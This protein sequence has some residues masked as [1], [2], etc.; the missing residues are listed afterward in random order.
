MIECKATKSFPG[1]LFGY[2]HPTLVLAWRSTDPA[3]DLAAVRVVAEALRPHLDYDGKLL[4]RASVADQ[5]ATARDAFLTVT[6]ALELSGEVPV[7]ARRIEEDSGQGEDAQGRAATIFAECV[8][9]PFTAGSVN[10][11]NRLL[12]FYN[13]GIAADELGRRAE[14]L[15]AA[16]LSHPAVVNLRKNSRHLVRASHDRALPVLRLPRGIAQYGWGKRSTV[17]VSSMTQNTSLVSSQIAKDKPLTRAVLHSA[18]LPVARQHN[19]RDLDKAISAAKDIGYPV[20]VKPRSLDGGKGVTTNIRDEATL[21]K[22]FAKVKA[23][24]PGV[25]VEEHL[26]GGEYRLLVVHGK[27]IAIHERVPAQVVANGRDTVAAL[28]EAENAKRKEIELTG[29][30]AAPIV[31][32]DETMECLSGQGLTMESV[33]DDGQTVRM[34]TV[35]KVQTGGTVRPVAFSEFHPDNIDAVLRAARFVRLDIAGIDFLTP[36]P[37]KSWRE[38]GGAITEVNAVP[39]INRLETFDVFSA[40]LDQLLPEGGRL[41]AVL[42][43]DDTDDPGFVAQIVGEA[44]NDK[45]DPGVL[46]TNPAR[47]DRWESAISGCT[48]IGDGQAV[49]RDPC[50]GSVLAVQSLPD[51]LANGY[52][53]D[54]FDLI[55][56]RGIADPA[57]A[58]QLLGAPFRPMFDQAD[59]VTLEAD[60]AAESFGELAGDR[61]QRVADEREM[62]KTLLA[63]LKS[64]KV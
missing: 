2:Q 26:T 1:Y 50:V 43:I 53:L 10:L 38:A 28:V 5:S 31:V 7:F 44:Q 62:A 52:A 34:A 22:A 48:A 8:N 17:G 24:A 37:A 51:I 32:N 14:K 61:L 56:V 40:V 20:V 36:D 25:I 42:L 64:G 39:Q 45:A 12:G 18:R 49:L 11:I 63:C 41:P 4:I 9:P 57:S 30:R 58:G 27:L 15:V 13:N 46:V 54:R 47:A 3:T 60:N 29:E 23:L 21:K 35:P 59:V 19:V 16:H 6:D 33:P 55:A